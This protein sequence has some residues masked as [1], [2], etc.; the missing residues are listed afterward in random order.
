LDELLDRAV[1][2]QM[3]SDVPLGVFL[4]GGIDSSLLVAH[5]ARHSARPV[6]TFSVAVEGGQDESPLADLV[7]RQFGT[8][9]TVLRT[10]D[11]GPERLLEL[12]GRL[13]EPFG[14]PTFVPTFSLS[15]LTRRYVKVALSGDGGDEVFGGYPKYLRSTTSPPPLP[16][17]SVIDRGLRAVPWRPR[18]AAHLYSR[19]LSA[20]DRFRFSWAGYGD[21]PVFRKDIRQLLERG[22]QEVAAVQDYFAPWQNRARRYGDQ[23]DADVLMRTDLETYLSENCLVKTDRASML[24]SLEVRVP[25]LD[26]IVLHRVLPLAAK[27]KLVGGQLKALLMP[28]ARRLLPKP[29]WDRP[30]QG[31]D[32]PI[33]ARLRGPW[34]PAVEAALGWGESYFRCFNYQYLR[35]LHA[36]NLSEGGVSREL[37]NPFALLAWAMTHSHTL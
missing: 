28:L 4:S 29:V 24:A 11:V 19:T 14:D 20:Q 31:F 13:D 37:W 17:G 7:A 5:M 25:Y 21:F 15:A 26:E 33:D 2:R 18:G 32:V 8:D 22:F 10:E 16:L 34:R 12:L 27:D 3:N 30:K 9:H 36:I 35:R 23:L 6:R 1:K